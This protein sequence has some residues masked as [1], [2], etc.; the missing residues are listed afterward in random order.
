MA[1]IR[2][3]N[4]TTFNSIQNSNLI[5]GDIYIVKND[6][7]TFDEYIIDNNKNKILITSKNASEIYL[8]TS[9]Y[10][11]DLAENTLDKASNKIH[12]EI[13]CWSGDR[14]GKARF[15]KLDNF[16]YKKLE[17]KNRNTLYFT[18]PCIT[19]SIDLNNINGNSF[20]LPFSST[21]S[22]DCL[23]KWGDGTEEKITSHNAIH[24]YSDKKI[25][26]IT[27]S[28]DCPEINFYKN[29]SDDEKTNQKY[30][31]ALNEVFLLDILKQT[32]C[33]YM[34]AGCS[35]L[36][37]CECMPKRA[38]DCSHMFEGCK[39]LIRTP[40]YSK[41]INNCNYMFKSCESLVSAFTIPS[42][43]IYTS[44]MFEDCINLE[45]CPYIS[46]S[47][48]DCSYMFN[49]CK[50]LINCQNF[51][52]S[53]I[54]AECMFKDCINL[55]YSP[56]FNP[57]LQN[58][59]QTF[60]NCKSLEVIDDVFRNENFKN[61]TNSEDCYYNCL[62]IKLCINNP[63]SI[64]EIPPEW[65]GLYNEEYFYLQFSIE[66]V[67]EQI[68]FESGNI[69]T[70]GDGTSS[71]LSHIYNSKAKYTVVT[72][73]D[74]TL[75]TSSN[76]SNFTRESLYEIK[77][78]SNSLSDGT[79]LFKNCINL[80]NIVNIPGNMISINSMFSNCESLISDIIIEEGVVSA[81]N[82]FE[83]CL[84]I[85]NIKSLPSTLESI[86]NAF[87]N[88]EL[89][90]NVESLPN[91]LLT[92]EYAFCK[93]L[94]LKNAPIMPNLITNIMGMY[95]ESGILNAPNFTKK[96]INAEKCFYK[97]T[98]LIST[99]KNWG[100]SYENTIVANRCYN[101]CTSLIMIDSTVY[102]KNS[103]AINKIPK[104]WK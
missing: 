104:N 5:A 46:N 53:M 24:T 29:Y 82:A 21:L 76:D 4:F 58:C 92:A 47:A 11:D 69:L 67:N 91:S 83:N 93:C 65:G 50:K 61:I 48:K 43:V 36:I 66:D 10:N 45:R 38:L 98:D 90:E 60:Y 3:V 52:S 68:I 15:C 49:N 103:D 74:M 39:K 26:E 8:D 55:I 54:N 80:E 81:D 79:N 88:C 94:S 2:K 51:P 101:E 40:I 86:N 85:Q 18:T 75:D 7:N 42:T 37:S 19:F 97:C 16:V 96:I 33:G 22:Y 72:S 31:E 63:I 70:W 73:K 27:I 56:C 62:N 59:K 41:T 102:K 34:F 13:F 12:N 9:K 71:G 87:Y 30:Q 100:V 44:H 14:E 25:Y 6:N 78:F 99:P 57:V 1:K 35:N 89:L 84:K 95:S 20:K 28:G 17:T 32:D 77:N 64:Y 23:V